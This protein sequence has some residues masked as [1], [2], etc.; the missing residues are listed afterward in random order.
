VKKEKNQ[1]NDRVGPSMLAAPGLHDART[2][3]RMIIARAQ[4]CVD[5]PDTAN[6]W[7]IHAPQPW[8][9]CLFAKD[10]PASNHYD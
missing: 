9:S 1:F 3:N 4:P 6:R 8:N 5:S 10:T 2:P 7:H